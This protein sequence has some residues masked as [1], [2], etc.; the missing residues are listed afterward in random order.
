[1]TLL[2]GSSIVEPDGLIST[3]HIGGQC[4]EK[5]A[6]ISHANCFMTLHLRFSYIVL[7]VLVCV[8]Y[9][10]SLHDMNKSNLGTCLTSDSKRELGI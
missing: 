10:L 8:H 2:S 7:R 9:G 4:E 1:M 6:T 3:E 5:Q